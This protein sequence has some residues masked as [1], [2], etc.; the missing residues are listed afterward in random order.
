MGQDSSEVDQENG[1]ELGL[2]LGGGAVLG[3]AH[4]GVLRAFEDH[5]WKPSYLSGTSIGAMVAVL[6][7]F[8]ISLNTIEEIAKSM[9]WLNISS[10]SVS[11]YGL[12]NNDELGK[13]MR[14]YI[15]DARLEEADIPVGVVAT[16]IASGTKQTYLEGPTDLLIRATTCIPGIFIPVEYEDR[17]LIDGGI[18]ENV[19]ISVLHKLNADPIIGVDL[20]AHRTYE[21]PD[22][23][24]D[25]LINTMDLAIDRPT[26]DHLNAT[27]WIQ[28]E[29]SSYNRTDTERIEEI[30]DKGYDAAE[31]WLDRREWSHNSLGEERL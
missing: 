1:K 5:D 30:I 23:I 11:R 20:S 28:P 9:S 27:S 26:V 3:A 2:A 18:M 10:F 17:M 21:Q 22:D 7:A 4:I 14:E 6:Y 31:I 8:G 15:G 25:I 19:P 12:F 16:D 13:I 29:L 24:I